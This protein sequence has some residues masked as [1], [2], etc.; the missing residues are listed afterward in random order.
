MQM[1]VFIA[2]VGFS[3]P[4]SAHFTLVQLTQKAGRIPVVRKVSMDSRG[5]SER[6]SPL[7]SMRMDE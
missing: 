2:A 1:T 7:I 5:V 6:Q 4:L 3:V